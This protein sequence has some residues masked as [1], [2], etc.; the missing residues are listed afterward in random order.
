MEFT[1][2]G[3]H[4]FEDGGVFGSRDG[5]YGSLHLGVAF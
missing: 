3:G 2:S 5:A 1:I 4:H